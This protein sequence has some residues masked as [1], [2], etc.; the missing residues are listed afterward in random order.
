MV[1]VQV[2]KSGNSHVAT[3]P[4][5]ELERLDISDGDF[6]N[7]EL[8]KMELKPVLNPELQSFADRNREGLVAMMQYL[9]DK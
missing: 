8:N 6:V 2:R 3:I 4:K 9:K 7:V 5:S 1:I